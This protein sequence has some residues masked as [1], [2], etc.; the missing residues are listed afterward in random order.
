MSKLFQESEEESV[1]I[2]NKIGDRINGRSFKRPQR[3]ILQNIFNRY[4]L[5]LQE[6]ISITISFKMNQ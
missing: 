2:L 1:E 4:G 5:F 3:E 6:I